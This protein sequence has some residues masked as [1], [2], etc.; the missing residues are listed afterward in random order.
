MST[1]T[2]IVEEQRDVT[3]HPHAYVEELPDRPPT[4]VIRE[5]SRLDQ[6]RA[7][8]AIAA[9]WL[10]IAAAVALCERFWSLPLY[11]CAVAFIGAR[12]HAL[13]VL[14]HDA[15]HFTLFKKKW[16]NDWVAD[17][18]L[19]WPVFLSVGVFRYF[20]QDHHRYLGTEKDKNRELW[21]T[22]TYEGT[23]AEDWRFPKTVPALVLLLLKKLA[24]VE[25]IVWI[26]SGFGAMF[27][28]PEYRKKSW[29][30]AAVRSAY[31]LCLALVIWRLHLGIEF[32]LYWIIPYCTWH[33]M[34]Q[35]IRIICEHSA[36]PST[37]PPYHLTR[38]TIP[39]LWQ[40]LL[41]IPR[42]IGYHHEHHWFPSVPFYNLPRLHAVLTSATKFGQC[43]A[44]SHG[45]V[46]ALRE[47]VRPKERQA[48]AGPRL[49]NAPA[50]T[51]PDFRS[52]ETWFQ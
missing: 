21:R 48:E 46:S 44:I 4:H 40:K 16:R 2:D 20:H 50:K 26:V 34:I 51:G 23:L 13:L 47:C 7:R 35:Y 37:E 49:S 9:E 14:G 38:T 15:S 29:P 10:A 17:L 28:R 30:Y 5:L 32:L 1:T 27:V 36:I 19:Y 52:M 18:A 12:Q 22:H 8:R 24:F 31:Y 6:F 11:L 25:G 41:I 3:D 39:S 33:I 45:V 43:G 42:N